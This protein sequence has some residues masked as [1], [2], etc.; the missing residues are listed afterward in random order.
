MKNIEV[1]AAAIIQDNK[2]LAAQR[3]YGNYK[4][5]WEF[6]GGKVEAGETLPQA[7]QRE[8]QEEMGALVQVGE[9]VG[10]VEHD[11]PEFHVKMHC[12]FCSVESGRLELKEHEDARWLDA[13]HLH[14]VNWL[15]SDLDLLGQVED[16]LSK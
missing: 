12:F 6:P 16:R 5:W 7:L 3:G 13:E 1:V 8:I 11:Y 2:V 4:G 14:A 9:L 15:A 10:T